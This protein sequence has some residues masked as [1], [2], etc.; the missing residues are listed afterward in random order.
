MWKRKTLSL[1][2]LVLFCASLWPQSP[3]SSVERLQIIVL[4]LI[5]LQKTKEQYLLELENTNNERRI[6]LA[7]MLSDLQ[8]R[9]KELKELK[10]QL[11]LFGSLI[12]DQAL[13][14][15][16]LQKNLTFWRI[17]SGILAAALTTSLVIHIVR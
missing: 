5:E 9:E 10:L 2:L 16:K 13:Y 3:S 1:L 17:T 14:S 11:E 8:E 12:D 7:A 4:E 6:E 15:K